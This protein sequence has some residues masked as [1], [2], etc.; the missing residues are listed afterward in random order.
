L[1]TPAKGVAADQKR[2]GPLAHKRCE[3]RFDLAAVAGVEDLDLQP[4]GGS[5]RFHISQGVL[6]DASERTW[7]RCAYLMRPTGMKGTA[8]MEIMCAGRSGRDGRN[9][10]ILAT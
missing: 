4:D 6:G 10:E 9:P 1:D 3:G 2:V 8:T 5:S 7:L